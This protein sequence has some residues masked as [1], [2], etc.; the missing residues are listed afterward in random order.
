L[1]KIIDLKKSVYNLAQDYP[2]IKEIMQELGFV[3]IIK[4][5]MLNTA[6]RFVTLP[7]GAA[8]LTHEKFDVSEQVKA[9]YN[10]GGEILAC[11]TCL[12]SRSMEGTDVC[13]L[14]TMIDCVK[15][16]EWADKVVTF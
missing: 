8:T 7:K 11:G 12:K 5:G 10:A 1:E 4:P 9:Y 14:S 16:V 2:E 3:D 13:P 6:G 15:M